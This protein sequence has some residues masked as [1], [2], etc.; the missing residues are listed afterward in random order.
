MYQLLFVKKKKNHSTV[1]LC[2]D[3]GQSQAP[4]ALFGPAE[5]R[6][7]QVAHLLSAPY[8]SHTLMFLVL[9]P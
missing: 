7:S 2:C 9:C 1:T 6:P 3:L 4:L 5:P 8:L